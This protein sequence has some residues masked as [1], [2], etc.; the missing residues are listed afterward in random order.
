NITLRA[1]EEFD[2]LHT[3]IKGNLEM[4]GQSKISLDELMKEISN[5]S[6]KLQTMQ[7]ELKGLEKTL[8]QLEQ[9]AEQFSSVSQE[10]L[11]SAE[12][13]LAASVIQTGQM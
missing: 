13:M 5:V 4:A 3:E 11:A 8:P 9:G 12:E 6:G 1:S 7:T 10:T 2:Q